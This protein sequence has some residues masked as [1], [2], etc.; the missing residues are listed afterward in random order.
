MSDSGTQVT[1]VVCTIAN[2]QQKYRLLQLLSAQQLFY[3]C[4]HVSAVTTEQSHHNAHKLLC[5]SRCVS[6]VVS[7]LLFM[8]AVVLL[9]SVLCSSV[10]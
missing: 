1:F 9:V 8:S 5:I 6:F 7:V 3:H 2:T 4:V 10:Q